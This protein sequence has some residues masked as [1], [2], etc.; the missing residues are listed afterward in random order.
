[1]KDSGEGK[2]SL[3]TELEAVSLAEGEALG[4]RNGQTHQVIK[5]LKKS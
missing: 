1:M 2:S 5:D 3:E 4:R